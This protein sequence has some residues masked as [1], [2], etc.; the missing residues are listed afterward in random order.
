MAAITGIPTDGP[1]ADLFAIPYDGQ[2]VIYKPRRHLAFIGNQAL[3]D[4]LRARGSDGHPRPDGQIEGFLE[5][6]GYDRPGLVCDE[7]DPDAP[8]RPTQ[9]VLL[10]TNRCTLRCVYC[11]ADAGTGPSPVEMTWPMA[12]AVIE[13]AIAN[14][15]SADAEPPALTFH[16]GGEPTVH[17]D[18]LVR[19]TEYA[20]ELDGRVRVSMSTNGVWSDA[21]RRF[22]C[23][24]FD[25]VSLSMDGTAVMQNR[26]RPAPGGGESFPAVMESIAA[27]D[28][29]GMDYGIRMTV[30]PDSVGEF[31]DGVRFICRG[32]RAKT[33]QIE[34]TF[35]SARGQYAD[36]SC[37]FADAF[38]ERFLEAMR[39]GRAAG[40]QVYYSAA[41]PWVIAPAFCLA[42][43]KALVA[44]ADGRLVTCFELFSE[45]SPQA[46]LF[47]VGRVADGQVRLDPDA[48]RAFLAAQQQR[49]RECTDCFCYWHCCGDC[50]T[51]RRG[52]RA[53]TSGRCRATR[54]ITLAL[55]LDFMEE[56][57][58]VW[59]GLR[60]AVP[61]PTSAAAGGNTASAPS[62]GNATA[63][64]HA[65][66]GEPHE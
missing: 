41:R 26:Q 16:G 28:E 2:F 34:P 53:A 58:G 31:V 12:R 9:A 5:S 65:P 14:A 40:R 19:A 50:A 17:W 57:G 56:G 52:S 22:V 3:V 63:D 64:N 4:Y 59:Q 38:S 54:G 24:H 43:L 30:L 48:M 60:E 45:Q 6:V 37:D 66:E 39:V 36:I 49:R 47:T 44:T 18:L 15:R 33:I 23:T 42:P 25:N 46:G 1:A 29:V 7:I 35:T 8:V 32:T 55:L 61:S 51:R 13:A 20:K 21:Q 10:M 27:L 62:A 11:Y